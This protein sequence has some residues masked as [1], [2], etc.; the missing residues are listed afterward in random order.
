MQFGRFFEQFIKITVTAFILSLFI[1][2]GL[3]Y[4]C[5]CLILG[6]VISEVTSFAFNY[7]LSRK[8]ELVNKIMLSCLVG[9]RKVEYQV[10]R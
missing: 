8:R 3:E 6:D 1:P 10:L 7:I 4:A 5:F 2:S 9:Y